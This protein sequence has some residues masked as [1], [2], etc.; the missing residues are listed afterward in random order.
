MN[1]MAKFKWNLSLQTI[2]LIIPFLAFSQEDDG[3]HNSNLYDLSASVGPNTNGLT[4]GNYLPLESL[5]KVDQINGLTSE[6]LA[7]EEDKKKKKKEK[8]ADGIIWVPVLASNPANGFM[9]G[10]APARNWLMG[11][12]ETTSYSSMLASVVFTT[13]SQMLLTL[14]GTAFFE[15]NNSLMMYDWRYF[16]TSQP[17]FGLGTGPSTSKLASNGFE[18]E[19]GLYSDKIDEPQ[20]MEFDFIRLYQ[21][22]FRRMGKATSHTYAG[23]GYHLDRHYKI[24]SNLL[25]LDTIPAVI[26]SDYAYSEKYDYNTSNYTLSGVSLNG[27]YDTRDNTV[28][29]Y[30]GR[31]GLITYKYNSKLIGSHQNSSTLWAEYRDYFNLKKERPRNLLAIWMYGN[32]QTSGNLPYLDLPALG[33]DQYGRSGRA[34]PQGRFRGQDLLYGEAEW[35]FPLQKDKEKWGAVLFANATSA[36]NKDADIKMFDYINTGF[37]GGLRYMLNEKSRTNLCLDYGVGNYGASGFYLSV[38]EVF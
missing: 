31:Y 33:W 13:K 6:S 24:Q 9:I 30:H 8:K 5:I 23:I 1:K 16:I 11:D 19:D 4:S 20:M 22:Y 29:P 36:T 12:P 28:N 37:G 14:K 21:T 18:Y 34:Y 26:P 32:F 7:S 35:R 10:V 2:L 38:N 15:G 3:I 17:T 27:L 25:N